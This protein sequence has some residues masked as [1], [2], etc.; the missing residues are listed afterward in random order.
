MEDFQIKLIDSTYSPEDAR[1]VLCS[2]LN[3]KIKFI[4]GQIHSLY[5]RF[6]SNTEHLKSRIE[7]LEKDK[8]IIIEQLNALNKDTKLVK[9]FCNIELE[10]KEIPK[11]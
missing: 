7:K 11:A 10:F 6:G 5:M 3:D 1:E 8:A 9:I 4:G 2:L